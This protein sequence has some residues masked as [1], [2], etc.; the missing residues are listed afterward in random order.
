MQQ[1]TLRRPM[2]AVV[3]CAAGAALALTGCSD[4]KDTAENAASA[5]TSAATDA[6]SAV[7]SKTDEAKATVQGL[8]DQKAQEILRTAV[9]PDTSGDEID[10]VVDTS[11]PATKAAIQA[12]AKGSSAAGYTP[13]IYSVKRVAAVD[14]VD[15]NKAA[16]A[17]VAV[18]SP[19]VPDPVDITLTYVQIDGTWKLSA[20]A[21][22]QLAGMGR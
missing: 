8:D 7:T 1:K 22:T 17:T 10:N 20:D 4:A 11:N 6:A 12:Y 2:L 14:D 18:K 13:D 5:V 9:N 19:H 21:V 16:E 15:G 3:A